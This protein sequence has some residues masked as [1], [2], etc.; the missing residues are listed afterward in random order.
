MSDRTILPIDAREFGIPTVV[1]TGNATERINHEQ[2]ITLDED[3][4]TVALHH[5]D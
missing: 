2:Q 1:G 5:D 4:G 3:A